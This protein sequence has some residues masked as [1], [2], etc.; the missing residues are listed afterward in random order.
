MLKELPRSKPQIAEAWS[1]AAHGAESQSKFVRESLRFPLCGRGDV[2]TYSIFAELARALTGDIG[3]AGIIVPSGIATDDTTKFF[4]R[5]LVESGSLVSLYD[6][7]NRDRIFPTVY[8][9][10]RF[11]LLTISGEGRQVRLGADCVFFAYRVEH[12]RD[13]KRRV[14]LTRDDISLVNPNTRTCPVFLSREDARIARDAYRRVPVLVKEGPPEH[15][16]WNIELTTMFHMSNDSHLFRTREQ[17]ER[18]GWELKGSAFIK[19]HQRYVPLYEAKMIQP[20]NHRAASVVVS[21]ERRFRQ[22]QPD[23]STPQQLIDPLFFRFPT[24][25]LTNRR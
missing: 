7:E 1:H 18:Q 6:F 10:M 20:F 17:L 23:Y 8:Y 5:A 16:P 15:N 3:R 9:R 21:S 19:D 2:N 4:F 24:I 13:P 25:T 11:C 14:V 12:L 22:G